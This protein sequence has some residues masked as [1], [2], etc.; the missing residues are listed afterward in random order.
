MSADT[1]DP[2]LYL[3]HIVEAVRKIQRYT[4]GGKHAFFGD[5]MVQDAVYRNFLVIG[6]ATKRLSTEIRAMDDAIPW[7]AMAGMRDVMVHRYEGIE[8]DLVWQII[9]EE[10]PRLD[11]RLLAMLDKLGGVEWP[12][13]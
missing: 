13:Q 9:E 11:Q 10:L 2:R 5:D 3:I 8:P 6:E 4:N 12:D 1:K 7:K